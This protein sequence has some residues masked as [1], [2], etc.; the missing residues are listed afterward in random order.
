MSPALLKRGGQKEG[1]SLTIDLD[2][3]IFLKIQITLLRHEV[4]L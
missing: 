3:V 4:Y 2:P 1:N